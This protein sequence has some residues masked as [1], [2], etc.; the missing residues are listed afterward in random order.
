MVP[1]MQHHFDSYGFW[2]DA[3]RDYE[4]H[5]IFDKLQSPE[6][7]QMARLIDPFFMLDELTM[8]KLIIA[9]ANDE[10]FLPDSSQFYYS[11]LQGD[12]RIRYVPNSGH[13]VNN[14]DVFDTLAIFYDSLI[15]SKVM[16]KLTWQKPS[17]WRL[18]VQIT[19]SPVKVL[20]WEA[21]TKSGR[22]F[23]FRRDMDRYVSRE[24]TIQ[25]D[26]QYQIDVSPASRGGYKAFFVEAQ[27]E[28]GPIGYMKL[29]TEVTVAN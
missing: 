24:I 13:F 3:V 18:D 11:R 4:N 12:N 23:R 29:T 2:S 9:A 1:S 7:A 16:P 25:R 14:F 20:L 5:G 22:D 6:V 10:F 28:D 21:Q 15:H 17:A 26:G 8:P 19:G 27:F